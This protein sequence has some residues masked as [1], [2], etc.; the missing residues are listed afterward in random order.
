MKEAFVIGKHYTVSITDLVHIKHRGLTPNS[1]L[2]SARQ[3]LQVSASAEL[4]VVIP[5]SA[6]QPTAG[7]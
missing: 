6:A 2:I 4:G 5:P 1:V 7:E 3:D